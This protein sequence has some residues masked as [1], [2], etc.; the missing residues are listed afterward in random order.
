MLY[1]KAL[2]TLE[3]VALITKRQVSEIAW[4]VASQAQKQG[5][6]TQPL[7]DRLRPKPK[8][9]VATPGALDAWHD[10][11]DTRPRLLVLGTG[12]GAHALVKVK[13]AF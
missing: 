9:G 2:D 7:L 4:V 13:K 3:D 1:E 11:L 8:G 10:K 12:W 6:D 5:V